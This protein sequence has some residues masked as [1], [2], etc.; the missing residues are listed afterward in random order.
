MTDDLQSSLDALR[1]ERGA[2]PDGRRRRRRWPWV[3]AAAALILLAFAWIHRPP[4]VSTVAAGRAAADVEAGPV[5][6]LNAS[7]Y[8]VARREATV[9]SKITGR[10]VAVMVD[11]G[12]RVD[13]GQVLARLDDAEAQ[14]AV[15]LAT[16]QLAAARKALGETEARLTLARADRARVEKL[17]ADGVRSAADLDA[18]KADEE[19]YGARLEQQ[20]EEIQVAQRA[21]AVQQQSLDNTVIRSPFAGVAISKNAQPGEMISP[22]SA[23][24]GFTRTGITTVV[25]MSSLEIE[26]D[27]NESYIQRVHPGQ[28][29]E[30]RLNAYPGRQIPA[31][32]ITTIPA[33]DRDK[34][35][36]KVR[37]GFEQLDPR[38][39]PDMGVK[40]TFLGNAGSEGA[41]EYA[42]V[43]DSA[44]RTEQGV[45]VVYVV[46]EG[47]LS[48]RA[49]ESGRH[50]A[51]K[52]EILSGV[53]PG[54]SVVVSGPAKLSDGE[55]VRPRS[56]A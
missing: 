34:A 30:A 51:G 40:V 17:V 44:L 22:V 4:A 12:M 55:R 8:V 45:T 14:R 1:I 42:E 27:V 35:T 25:D 28:A 20:R 2:E 13:A 33:A 41:P 56:A 39:L 37:I 29:V 38:I 3:V 46:A 53:A 48:R 6:V 9:S 52:T 11:E 15:A 47:K 36:V 23:G 49:V 43:P 18:S 26:V 16:A 7:G 31:H 10:V 19:A 21:L 24:G 54:E 32:V 50:A 5:P